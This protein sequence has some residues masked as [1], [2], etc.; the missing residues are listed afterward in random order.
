MPKYIIPVNDLKFVVDD[1]KDNIQQYL[2]SGRF[3]EQLELET[4]SKYI[5]KKSRILDIGS[6]IGNHAVY[7]ARYLDP[8]VVYVIEPIQRSYDLL[9]ETVLINHLGKIDMQFIGTALGKDHGFVEIAG[10]YESNL[11]SVYLKESTNSCIPKVPGDYLFSSHKIDFIKIDVE[12]MELEVLSGLSET[13]AKNRPYI[14]LESSIHLTEQ[15]LSWVSENNYTIVK[16]LTETPWYTNY[17][18]APKE[19]R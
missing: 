13:I 11:G 8:D 14:C 7:F 2:F 3:Y 6:N 16:I 1:P 5:P 9:K 19:G 17:L 4:I 18:L 12:G 10:F 15:S